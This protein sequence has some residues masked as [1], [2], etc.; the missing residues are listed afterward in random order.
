VGTLGRLGDVDGI[1]S[2]VRRYRADG[3]LVAAL[4]ALELAGFGQD[5]DIGAASTALELVP[6]LALL[7][8]RPAP[9]VAAVAYLLANVASVLLDLHAVN[10][11]A[12]VAT[13]VVGAYSAGAWLPLGRALV[14]LAVWFAAL[15]V[16]F[17]AGREQGADDLAF[18]AMVL[19]IAFTPGVVARRLRQQ[20]DDA[21]RAARQA[22]ER[23]GARAAEAVASERARIARELHD[24]VAHAVSIMVVQAAAAE[25][26]LERDPAR[27]RAALGAVQ[28]SG[29]AAVRELARM[30]DLLRGTPDDGLDP[31]PTLDALP[32]LVE[33]ARLSGAEVTLEPLEVGPLPPAVELCAYR[34]V[35]EALTNAAKHTREPHARVALGCRDGRLDVLVEDDGGAGPRAAEGTGHGLL[36]LRERVA[37]FD[38][39]LE[40]GPRP[41]GGFRVHAVLPL[42][43]TA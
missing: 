21:G 36:G 2:V 38:G 3:A 37:V 16:D 33:E 26:L 24:V 42:G 1:G 4:V 8:R 32:R 34:V 31:L 14:T 11:G 27:A 20:A 39:T 28:Q 41:G 40:A 10:S 9:T 17:V 43:G 35:Q 25:E 18:A 6:I 22:V 30:L 15:S 19:L 23:E 13:I 12:I 7:V 5:P 29:R